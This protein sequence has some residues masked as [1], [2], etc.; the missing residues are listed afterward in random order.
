MTK[1]RIF[2]RGPAR[3]CTLLLAAG[4]FSQAGAEELPS[5]YVMAV[6]DDRAQG[7]QL[8]SGEYEG[9]IAALAEGGQGN[10][11]LEVRNN[12]CVAYAM[13]KRLS[14]AE[15]ACVQALR[16]SRKSAAF[17]NHSYRRQ[18]EDR[19]VAYSNRGVIRA[20]SGDIEGAM[21][22]FRRA[23]KLSGTF[24]PAAHNLARLNAKATP[25]VSSVQHAH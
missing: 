3:A 25:A 14:K 18:R 1:T 22:D 5:A 20:V 21:E 9:A 16:S 12:L 11:S 10:A 24:E 19:A 6:F 15:E 7:Q 4:A 13:T 23:V 2:R 8:V 17:W